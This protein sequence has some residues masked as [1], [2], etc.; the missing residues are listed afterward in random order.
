[1]AL[2]RSVAE[3]YCSLASRDSLTLK[4]SVDGRTRDISAASCAP[5]NSRRSPASVPTKSPLSRLPFK[6]RPLLSLSA[7]PCVLNS[8]A[9][10][11]VSPELPPAMVPPLVKVP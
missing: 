2:R 6:K 11:S 10:L 8:M 9:L 7:V 3:R 4:P 5:T 1:M